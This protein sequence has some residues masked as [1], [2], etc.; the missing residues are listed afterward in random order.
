[1]K[2]VSGIGVF[3]VRVRLGFQRDRDETHLTVRD[4]A[5]RD[6]AIGEISHRP[7][8]SSQHCHLETVLMIEMDMH[9]RHMEVMMLVMRG[10][11]PF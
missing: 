2:V 5:L 4:A 8:L 7:G 1:M 3:A 11:E 6:D 9:R 10:C